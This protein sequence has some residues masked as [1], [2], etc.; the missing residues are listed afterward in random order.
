MYEIDYHHNEWWT[1]KQWTREKLDG[2]NNNSE[3]WLQCAM[4]I[5]QGSL[6]QQQDRYVLHWRLAIDQ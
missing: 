1:Q 5:V 6:V 3:L 2:G 4:C